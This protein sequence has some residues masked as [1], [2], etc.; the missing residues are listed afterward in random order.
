M[1]TN[2]NGFIQRYALPIII[3]QAFVFLGYVVVDRITS[4][5]RTTAIEERVNAIYLQL[6]R[7]NE[8]QTE[9]DDRITDLEHKMLKLEA[10]IDD[11]HQPQPA[12]PKQE[13]RRLL[14]K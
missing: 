2:G 11:I 9:Q 1:T 6:P 8:K 3:G 13:R 10:A 4:E 14:R 7:L 12:P 5:R